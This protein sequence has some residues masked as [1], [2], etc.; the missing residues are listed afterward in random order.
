MDDELRSALPMSFGRQE[1]K[2]ARADVAHDKTKRKEVSFGPPRPPPRGQQQQ[3]Q[4]QELED[5]AQP[6]G[7]AA[8]GGSGGGGAFGPPRP[9]GN[10]QQRAAEG[11]DGDA[12]LVGP[13]RPPPSG[14]RGEGGGGGGS[15]ASDASDDDD[16]EE[17]DPYRLP[18]SNEV[19]LTGAERAV[20]CLDV[21]HTGSRVA[22]GSVDNVVRLYDFNGMRSDLKP[23]REVTPHDGHPVYSVSWS[24]TGDSFLAVTGAAQAKIYDRDGREKGEFI[25]GDMYIRDMR[26]T[27]GHVSGLTCGVWHP[28]DRFTAMTASEDGTV[29]IWDTW[30]VLQKTVIKPSLAGAGR[31]AVSSCAYNSD[32]RLIAAGIMDGTIQVWSVGGK[33]GRSAA[34]GAV[35]PPS[36]QH[37]EKQGWSYVSKPSQVARK[38][39]EPQTEITGLAFTQDDRT[40]ASRGADGTLRLW[41]LRNFKS[42][43]KTFS[44][45]PTNYSTTNVAFSPDERLVMTGTAAED[46]RNDAGGGT[47]VFVD[48]K[49]QRVVRALGMPAHAAAVKWHDRINQIFVGVG[50]RKSGGTHVLYDPSFS[51]RGALLPVARA[52][53]AASALDFV[54]LCIKTPHALPMFREEGGMSLRKRGRAP[55]QAQLHPGLTTP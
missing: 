53:R 26:N 14:S 54:P 33:F 12:G 47:V 10:H 16:E 18:I 8:A 50:N 40:L 38:A 27:K 39:H 55:E 21:E 52:P 43:L 49:E 42:P 48:V 11:A 34:I 9:P 19:V 22:A 44:G 20:T 31:V 41:D 23:F 3:Q 51:E 32:G 1:V 13:P 30:N 4:Q 25:R 7:R 37:I 24:P 35:Q 36:A 15:D 45:L 46:P 28:T 29:R 17:A 5:E 6:S 2:A